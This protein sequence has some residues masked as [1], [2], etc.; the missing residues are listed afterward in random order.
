MSDLIRKQVYI[1]KN[2]NKKYRVSN[3]KQGTDKLN[4][5][6]FTFD[7]WVYDMAYDGTQIP[8]EKIKFYIQDK[9]ILKEGDIVKITEI[10]SIGIGNFKNIKGSY[11]K[12]HTIFCSVEKI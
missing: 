12:S 7:F 2:D 11:E 3:L 5:P 4:R 1:G 9:C 8:I 6:Y 10:Y